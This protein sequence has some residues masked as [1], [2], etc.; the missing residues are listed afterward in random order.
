[1]C[2]HH[3]NPFHCILPP[4][5]SDKLRDKSGN[6]DSKADNQFRDKRKLLASIPPAKKKASMATAGTKPANKIYR[7]L[8]DAG[9]MPLAL[10]KLIWKEG[11]K[12]I[13]ADKDSKN[14]ISG[15]GNVWNFYKKLFNRNSLDNHGLPLIQTI[16]YR[17]NPDEPFYNAFWDGEQMFYGTGDPKFTNSFTGDLDIIGHELTHGVIDFEAQLAYENQ[18]GALNESYADVFGILIKQWVN[19]T[20][21]RK[22]D[23]LIGS[24]V[25][26]GKNALRSMKA[27]GTA[28][29]NDPIFGDDPQPATMKEFKHMPNTEDGDFGGVHYNSGIT[30]FAFYVASYE[31]NGNAWEKTGPIWYAALTDRKALHKKA[32][33]ADAAAATLKKA[34]AQFG[35]NSLEVKAIEKGWKEA[36]V[37]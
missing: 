19:K 20:P 26:K 29:Q 28:F 3:R 2:T 9:Q 31:I 35:K 17:E 30:N 24:N 34:T 16:R 7:E 1:M 37:I 6:T 27:P 15:A 4:Y 14:V 10:G 18:S 33:F 36:G 5:M 23:W 25:L 21:A 13:P 11:Q 32:S 12:K 22:A 8:Y